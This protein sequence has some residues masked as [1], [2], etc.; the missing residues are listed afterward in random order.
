MNDANRVFAAWTLI[1]IPSRLTDLQVTTSPASRDLAAIDDQGVLWSK[2]LSDDR[3]P[4]VQLKSAEEAPHLVS[5][6]ASSVPGGVPLYVGVDDVGDV[7]KWLGAG[8]SWNKFE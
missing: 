3:S 8:S 7:Y 1:D 5:I 6:A 4:W 2:S